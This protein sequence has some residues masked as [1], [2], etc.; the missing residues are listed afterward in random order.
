MGLRCRDRHRSKRYRIHRLRLSG[1]LITAYV[2]DGADGVGYTI[3]RLAVLRSAHVE[4]AADGVGYTV[5][6]VAAS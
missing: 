6:G 5:Y 4:D 1:V 3:Y 2:D